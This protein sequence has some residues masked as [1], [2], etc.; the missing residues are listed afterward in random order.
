MKILAILPTYNEASNITRV[1][2][3]LHDKY[4]EIDILHIDDNSP[5][6]TGEIAQEMEISNYRQVRNF[7]KLGLGN[8]YKQGFK[9]AIDK[10]YDFLLTMDSD[11]SH[12]IDQIGD[13][14]SQ[15]PTNDLV[16]GTRWIS[17]GQ[18]INWPFYRRWLSKFGTWYSRKMIKLPFADLTSG[19]RIYKVSKLK[20]LDISEID[21]KGYVFQIQMVDLIYRAGG[22]I[23]E[24]PITFTERAQGKSKM[25]GKIAREAFI[26]ITK[27]GFK[28]R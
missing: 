16:I 27:A 26:W 28:R 23:K 6:G 4:P 7:N 15:I 22:L 25:S 10:N 5:D 24:V 21:A 20:S 8:A 12:H 1:L 13:F 18:V 19:F 14:L 11:G 17:G 3:E 9:W 2:R